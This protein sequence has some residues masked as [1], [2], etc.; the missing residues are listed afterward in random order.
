MSASNN[1]IIGK[2]AGYSLL[3]SECVFI[4]KDAGAGNVNNLTGW[5]NVVIGKDAGLDINAAEQTVIIGYQA[6]DGDNAGYNV[7]LGYQ[8]GKNSTSDSSVFIG[9]RAGRDETASNKLIIG[10]NESSML[11]EGHFTEEWVRI[12]DAIQ[13]GNFSGTAQILQ[14]TIQ[15]LRIQ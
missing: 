2:S 14:L 5:Q 15:T 8:A 7:I 13:V 11:I 6:Q 4:G 10:N 9:Y 3:G 12:R 1:T